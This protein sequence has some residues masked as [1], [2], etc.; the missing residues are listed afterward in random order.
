MIWYWMRKFAEYVAWLVKPVQARDVKRHD[1]NAACP[2]CGHKRGSLRCVTR[3][4]P[5]G[6][7]S[8]QQVVVTLDQHTC[9][10]CGARWHEQP[11]VDVPSGSVW[12]HIDEE[13]AFALTK[14]I[15]RAS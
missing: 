13:K 9:A 12:Q 7:N 8:G 5:N 14:N 15:Q 1:Q 11:V 3:A 4:T 10:V 2:V 6:S